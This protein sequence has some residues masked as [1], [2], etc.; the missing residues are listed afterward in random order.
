[1]SVFAPTD[2]VVVVFMLLLLLLLLLLIEEVIMFV[3]VVVVMLNDRRDKIE[4]E[5]RSIDRR[6]DYGE[7]LIAMFVSVWAQTIYRNM[8]VA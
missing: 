2:A 1:V 7:R 5:E 3:V 8:C 6:L 4:V